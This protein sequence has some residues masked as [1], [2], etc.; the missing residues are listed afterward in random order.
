MGTTTDELL[1]AAEL[2][3]AERGVEGVSLREIGTAA[4]QRNNSAAQYHFGSKAGLLAALLERRMV[5]VNERR[6]ELLGEITSDDGVDPLIDS[7]VD[8]WFRPLAEVVLVDPP[9][10]YARFVAQVVTHPAFEE[11]RIQHHDGLMAG[12]IDVGGRLIGALDHLP[13][14]VAVERIELAGITGVHALAQLERRATTAAT[15]G[16]GPAAIEDVMT[17]LLDAIGGL[18]RAPATPRR[19]HPEGT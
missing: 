4:R 12:L 1:D 7:L 9:T 6:L 8:A 15:S 17:N 10:G 5:H 11:F 18:L 3:I 19:N 16:T 13:H 2:L 14:E